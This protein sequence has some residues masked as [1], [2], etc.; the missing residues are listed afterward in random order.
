VAYLEKLQTAINARQSLL[1]VGLDPDLARLPTHFPSTPDGAFRFL[2]AIIGSTSDFACAYKPN[3]AFFEALG[4]AGLELL[5]A[6]LAVIPSDIPVIGD[7]KRG[8]VGHTAHQYA[9]ALFERYHVDAVTVN[10]YLGEDA[11]EPFLAHADRGIYIVCRTSNPGA[12]AVQNLPVQR[13]GETRPLYEHVALLV[14]SWNRNQ[15]CGLVVGATAPAELSQIRR[16]TPHLPLLVPGVGEQG[17]DLV[18]AVAVHREDAPV[19]I[20]ASRSILYASRG[21]DFASAAAIVARNLRDA[22]RRAFPS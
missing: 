22:I 21:S 3:L 17:G 12:A 8:D 6:T 16:L 14:Q 1:C 20:N 19:V 9:V 2:R 7:A 5:Q 13:N 4:P 18:T 11:L 10:P 15:N